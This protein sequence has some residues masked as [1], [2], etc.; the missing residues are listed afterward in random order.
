MKR[1]SSIVVACALALPALSHAKKEEFPISGQFTLSS[2]ARHSTFVPTEGGNFGAVGARIA[3]SLFYAPPQLDGVT[4][5]G[6]FNFTKAIYESSQRAFFQFQTQPGITQMSDLNFGA[7]WNFAKV[8]P[9]LFTASLD[10][11]VAFS[12]FSRALGI[13]FSTGPSV[14][15]TWIAP[16]G[17]I[18]SASASAGLNILEN[19]TAQIDAKKAPDNVRVSGAD[20]GVANQA[21]TTGWSLGLSYQPVPGLFLG[22]SY[23]WQNWISA[24]YGPDDEFTAS[25]V[26]EGAPAQTGLQTSGLYHGTSFSIRYQMK[27]LGGGAA[28]AFNEAAGGEDAADSWTNHIAVG[29]SMLTFRDFYDLDNTTVSNP[30]FDDT[31]QLHTSTLYSIF[32]TGMM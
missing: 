16:A 25:N 8:G 24:V 4:F 12:N 26:D 23:F 32:I 5:Y 27:Q 29:L 2:R 21:G 22:G 10:N 6:S 18:V 19:S 14:G 3:A 20:V 17:I 1:L 31:P 30:F 9:V 13:G 28:D 15:V 7:N 11:N